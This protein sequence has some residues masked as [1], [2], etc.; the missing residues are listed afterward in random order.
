VS[1]EKLCLPSAP[2]VVMGVSGSGKSTVG[3]ALARRLGVQ[4][5]DADTFHPPANVAKMAAGEPLDDNDRY[6]W[7]DAV[8]RWLEG[9]G[10]GVLSCSAL[11]R[12]YRD[13]LRS[14]CSHI[15]FLHLTGSP[16]L[17][18]RR[19]AGRSGHFMPSSLVMSQFDTLEPLDP[20]E[21]GL[22]VD[23]GQSVEAIVETFLR[24]LTEQPRR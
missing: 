2:V 19:H 1:A 11:K 22:A 16:A 14:H 13:Q 10:D 12:R 24:Y 5:A 17:I 3:E 4:F 8:G 15:E 20:D 9:H 21:H 23:V 6:P 7:L 18:G